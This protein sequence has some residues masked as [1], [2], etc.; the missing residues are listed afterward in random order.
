MAVFLDPGAGTLLRLIKLCI[1][2]VLKQYCYVTPSL[3]GFK[4]E[5]R[6]ITPEPS[7]GIILL[8]STAEEAGGVW[9]QVPTS[10]S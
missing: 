2:Q 10:W 7:S 8:W 3:H 1:L 6:I 4:T 9:S 5:S